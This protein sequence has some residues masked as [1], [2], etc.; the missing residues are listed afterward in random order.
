[1]VKIGI[2]F[3]RALHVLVLK[4]GRG[5]RPV[6]GSELP[7]RTQYPLPPPTHFSENYFVPSSRK[8]VCVIHT[9]YMQ[10]YDRGN[11]FVDETSRISF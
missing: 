9:K 10:K 2:M 1:M 4:W 6:S 3:N 5:T 7:W 11:S 8:R